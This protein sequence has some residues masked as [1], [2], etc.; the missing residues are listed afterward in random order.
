MTLLARHK[1]YHKRVNRLLTSALSARH[2]LNVLA[3]TT[4][5]QKPIRPNVQVGSGV[6]VQKQ[7]R[8]M[9]QGKVARVWCLKLI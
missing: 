5:V 7:L 2:V 4:I 1:R 3:T 9:V 8:R 6:I